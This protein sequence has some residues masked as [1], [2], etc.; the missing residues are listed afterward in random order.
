MPAAR[1]AFAFGAEALP[2]FGAPAADA[3]G[4]PF[5]LGETGAAGGA[6]ITG[7]SLNFATSASACSRVGLVSCDRQVG[8][9]RLV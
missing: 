7:S 9:V 5:A 2:A 3:F 1:F 6:N 8:L 4:N